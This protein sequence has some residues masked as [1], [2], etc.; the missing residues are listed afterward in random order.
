[1]VMDERRQYWD[2]HAPHYDKAMAWF[3]RH[4]FGDSRA[5]V[6]SQATG[7]AL[8]VGIGT[9]LNLPHYP[10]GTDLT[11]ID[12]SPQML[13]RA[14][15]RAAGLGVDVELRQGDAQDLPYEAA[16][17]DTVVATF[18][19][20]AV[21]D[22]SATLSEVDRVLRPGGRLLLA[23]HVRPSNPPLRWFLRGAQWLSDRFQPGGGEQ[24][25]RRPRGDVQ[26]LGYRIHS[27][28]RF[29]GGVV[30]RLTAQK[31]D[32]PFVPVD[33]VVP[34][35]L[36]VGEFR[37][38]PLAPRHNEADHAAWTSSI[39][40]IQATPGFAGWGW[41]PTDGMSLAE[42]EGDLRRHADDFDNRVGFTY[43]VL[44]PADD[45][46]GCLYIY[47]AKDGNGASVRSWVRADH[48]ALDEPLY[49]AVSAWLSNDWPFTAVQ[50]A[51][52]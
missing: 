38:E 21:P 48:A 13:E 20:C 24:F 42:N 11:G 14:R 44:D 43:T 25:L 16:A 45:V 51:A 17:F 41:P 26:R 22:V 46:V 1:M 5:W 8:E 37:L 34:T 18:T 15:T 10:K 7:R 28:Q 47:P 31:P 40:H 3:D 6:C 9:G 32:E 2:D 33:F 12:L 23:D 4:V 50:Y 39:A 27:E 52:R 36:T 30:E 35:S 19:L 29:K 49:R